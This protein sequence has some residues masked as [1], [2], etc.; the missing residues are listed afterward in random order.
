[1]IQNNFLKLVQASKQTKYANEISNMYFDLFNIMPFSVLV[2]PKVGNFRI[3]LENTLRTAHNSLP[4]GCITDLKEI[5]DEITGKRTAAKFDDI[6][7]KMN[8]KLKEYSKAC[9]ISAGKYDDR[10]LIYTFN[11][12]CTN[13]NRVVLLKADLPEEVYLKPLMKKKTHKVIKAS[14]F[15]K[16]ADFD[17]E[18]EDMFLDEDEADEKVEEF[19]EEEPEIEEEEF[20]EEEPESESEEEFLEE[21]EI[22]EEEEIQVYEFDILE[23][24]VLLNCSC[25]HWVYGGAEYFAQQMDYLYGNPRGPATKP[26]RPWNQFNYCCKHV[27]RTYEFLRQN[28]IIVKY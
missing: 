17:I 28:P 9:T 3:E 7:F 19:L 24:D 10:K 18:R 11:L 27:Y 15:Y 25:P 14:G 13:G 21:P 8:P 26:T 1:M 22:E 20:I 16:N 2:S 4:I 23:L 12:R 6:T 5:H